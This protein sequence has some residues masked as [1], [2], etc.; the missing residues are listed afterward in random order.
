[1][2]RR[3]FRV[4]RFFSSATT[5]SLQSKASDTFLR[6]NRNNKVKSFRRGGLDV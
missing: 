1:V 5:I 2:R 3:L 4:A 6:R